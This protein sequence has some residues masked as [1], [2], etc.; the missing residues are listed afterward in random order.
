MLCDYTNRALEE[1]ELE[2][3][4]LVVDDDDDDDE[5]EEDEEEVVT[6]VTVV[7]DPFILRTMKTIFGG[8]KRG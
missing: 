2:E 1:L 4:E 8:D 6:V 3:L 7:V 5:E